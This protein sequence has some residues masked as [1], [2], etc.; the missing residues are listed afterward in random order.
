MSLAMEPGAPVFGSGRSR[1]EDFLLSTLRVCTQQRYAEALEVLEI[2]LEESEGMSID[3]MDEAGLDYWIADWMVEEAETAA[4]LNSGDAAA[5]QPLPRSF[6][7][8]QAEV[9]QVH[10]VVWSAPHGR[11]VVWYYR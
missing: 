4:V 7:E 8:D 5:V 11:H 9:F 3:A 2:R 6:F 10:Q 1:V